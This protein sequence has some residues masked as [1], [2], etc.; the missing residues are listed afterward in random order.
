MELLKFNCSI[1][2]PEK[3][4]VD[5]IHSAEPS[6]GR[7]DGHAGRGSEDDDDGA[8]HAHD[9]LL[10]PLVERGRKEDV[11][12]WGANVLSLLSWQFLPH[13]AKELVI[14]LEN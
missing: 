8:V 6:A 5:R 3:I 4:N 9:Q 1:R 14:F 2:Y 10:A 11:E 12:H 13:Y 7:A